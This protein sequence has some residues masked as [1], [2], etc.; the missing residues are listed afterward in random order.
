VRYRFRGLIRETGKPVDGHVEAEVEEEAFNALAENGIVTEA[1]FADPK[2]NNFLGRPQQQQPKSE[3]SDALDSAF[4]SSATQIPFDALTDRFKGKSVWVIDRDKIRRRVAQVVDLAIAQSQQAAEGS[5]QTRARVA[6]AIEGLF[7]DNRNITSEAS[8]SS[9][10]L[11]QQIQRLGN[12]IKQA[13]GV[14][15]SMKVAIAR[16]GGWGGGG[17]GGGRRARRTMREEAPNKVLFEILKTNLELRGITPP[18]DP[19][20]PPPPEPVAAGAA[21]STSEPPPE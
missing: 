2:P 18:P 20:A 1:L 3:F 14:L 21:S 8:K 6:Q 11:E 19:D 12:V 10:A 16:G 13:E 9:A 15:A 17:D 4:D 7:R 5:I